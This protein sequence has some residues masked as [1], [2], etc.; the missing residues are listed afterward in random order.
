MGR[1]RRK[2]E[3]TKEEKKAVRRVATG[4]NSCISDAPRKSREDAVHTRARHPGWDQ[5]DLIWDG[6]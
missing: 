3:M 5:G 1:V 6:V 4:A 2:V